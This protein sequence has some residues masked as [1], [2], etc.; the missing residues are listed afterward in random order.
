MLKVNQTI[1]WRRDSI[2]KEAPS[3]DDVIQG[4][5]KV[6]ATLENITF[7]EG[8]K[9]ELKNGRLVFSGGV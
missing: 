3:L 1:E 2:A 5:A 8:S 9:V 7:H 6:V 4:R